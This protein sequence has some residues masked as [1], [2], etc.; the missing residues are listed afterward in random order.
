MKQREIVYKNIKKEDP[1]IYEAISGELDRQ[2][3]SWR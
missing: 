3:G 1:Q 2:Q